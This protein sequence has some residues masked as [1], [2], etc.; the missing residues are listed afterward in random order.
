MNTLTMANT[1]INAGFDKEQA[2]AVVQIV[3]DEHKALATKKDLKS[4][5]TILVGLMGVG[6][7]YVISILNTLIGKI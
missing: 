3:D 1:L 6:F 4:G 2:E 5:F 7:G